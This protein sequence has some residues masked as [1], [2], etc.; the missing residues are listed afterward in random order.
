MIPLHLTRGGGGSRRPSAHEDCSF[1]ALYVWAFKGLLKIHLGALF[2]LWFAWKSLGGAA[3]L[4]L[5]NSKLQ[6]NTWLWDVPHPS[7]FLTPLTVSLTHNPVVTGPHVVKNLQNL[8]PFNNTKSTLVS[9]TYFLHSPGWFSLPIVHY[10][11]LLMLFVIRY[12]QKDA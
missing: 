6:T 10:G 7:S 5:V 12:V 1:P 3:Q 2:L 9:S 8:K 4:Y 11:R